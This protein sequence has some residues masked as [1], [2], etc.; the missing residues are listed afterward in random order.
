LAAIDYYN[1]YYQLLWI[2][3]RDYSVPVENG[4]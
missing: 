3:I 1:R 2:T 4:A